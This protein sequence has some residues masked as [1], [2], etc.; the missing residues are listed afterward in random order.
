MDGFADVM[1]HWCEWSLAMDSN[2][3]NN[4]NKIHICIAP[5]CH[6]FR[7]AGARQCAGERKKRK[8]SMSSA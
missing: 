5:Y 7:G 1:Y 4:Y 6:N 2:N 3:N 8:E